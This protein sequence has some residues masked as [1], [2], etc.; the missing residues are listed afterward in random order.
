MTPKNMTTNRM[1][2]NRH[3]GLVPHALVIAG[4]FRNPEIPTFVG[5][6]SNRMT[7]NRHYKLVPHALV[8][9]GLFRNPR[10]RHSSE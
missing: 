2:L 5:M 9:A 1:T 10:F 4:L 6:T 3:C 7:L 8:I